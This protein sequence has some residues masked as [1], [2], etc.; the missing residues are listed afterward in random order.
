MQCIAFEAGMR[1]AML[2][3]CSDREHCNGIAGRL[4][5]MQCLTCRVGAGHASRHPPALQVCCHS[6]LCSCLQ[7]WQLGMPC[8]PPAYSQGMQRMLELQLPCSVL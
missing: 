7:E 4:E 2:W 8:L 5:G 3:R 6:T 1:L